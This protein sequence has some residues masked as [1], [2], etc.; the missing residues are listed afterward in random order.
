MTN[1][2]FEARNN[3]LK[4]A[5]FR[6]D[7]EF[8]TLYEDIEREMKYFK[9][10]IVGKDVFCPCDNPLTS[11]FYLYFIDYF[12]EL[13]LSSALFSWLDTDYMIKVDES[14]IEKMLENRDKDNRGIEECGIKIPLKEKGSFDSQES[15]NIMKKKNTITITNPPFSKSTGFKT[16]LIE[17]NCEFILM[18]H[19]TACGINA[20]LNHIINKKMHIVPIGSLDFKRPDGSVSKVAVNW[21]TSFDT[22]QIKIKKLK[23]KKEKK[24]KK[25]ERYKIKKIENKIGVYEVPKV[26]ILKTLT[27]DEMKDKIF[28]VP[29]TFLTK[30]FEKKWELIPEGEL[31]EN[32]SFPRLKKY[33]AEDNTFNSYSCKGLSDNYI[34]IRKEDI[35]GKIYIKDDEGFYYKE[36]FKRVYIKRK[37]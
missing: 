4:T 3:N 12:K 8:Y 32:F 10:K 1:K 21:A 30:P 27:E 15:I 33:N 19:I 13:E 26:K 2:K 34:K 16:L 25:N 29:V 11:N 36:L 14:N 17:N 24:I 23:I 20:N 37:F 9:D 5:F 7:D 18:D 6:R 28:T 35:K 22:Y 31:N